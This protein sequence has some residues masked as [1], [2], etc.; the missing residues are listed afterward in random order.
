MNN[1]P[2]LRRLVTGHDEQG[3]AIFVYDDAIKQTEYDEGNGKIAKFGVR[4]LFFGG[5][6]SRILTPGG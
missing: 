1:L 4:N 5:V 3:K 2:P 6:S